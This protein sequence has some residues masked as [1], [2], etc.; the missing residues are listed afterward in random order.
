M[1]A[2]LLFR[3]A[4]LY[5]EALPEVSQMISHAIN[6]ATDALSAALETLPL[7]DQDELVYLFHDHLPKTLADLGFDKVRERVPEQ[8]IK[9]AIASTLASKMVYKEGT[10]FIISLPEGRL[11]ETALGYIQQEKEV[12]KLIKTLEETNMTTEEKSKILK[13]LDAGGARTALTMNR[14]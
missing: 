12:I 7:E 2:E 11:A 10:R 1:E 9:N 8:Y 6:S 3:E 5:G 14:Q 13:L 4:E